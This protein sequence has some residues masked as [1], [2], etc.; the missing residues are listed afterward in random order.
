[1]LGASASPDQEGDIEHKDLVAQI[2][3]REGDLQEVRQQL[4]LA[5]AEAESLERKEAE[6]AQ[7][8]EQV[9]KEREALEDQ[10]KKHLEAVKDTKA[11]LVD[12]KQKLKDQLAKVR[13]A[14]EAASA[15]AKAK[16]E[17]AKEEQEERERAEREKEERIKKSRLEAKATAEAELLKKA[18]EEKAVLVKKLKVADEGGIFIKPTPLKRGRKK[19]SPKVGEG[20]DEENIQDEKV[21]VIARPP[22]L[23]TSSVSTPAISSA[24]SAHNT[25]RRISKV[26]RKPGPKREVVA[27][28]STAATQASSSAKGTIN[29]PSSQ[30]F[31][32]P[33]IASQAK[34]TYTSTHQKKSSIY[35]RFTT[36]SSSA[37]RPKV[38]KNS[39]LP[40][41]NELS[42]ITSSGS[43]ASSP[44]LNPLT[45]PEPAK[46]VVATTVKSPIYEGLLREIQTHKPSTL[47]TAPLASRSPPPS[48]PSP[49]AHRERDIFAFDEATDSGSELG[50][51]WM[52]AFSQ[53]QGTARSPVR[54]TGY[55]QH[56]SVAQSRPALPTIHKPQVVSPA[57][58]AP[59]TAFAISTA[60]HSTKR[61]PTKS[62]NTTASALATPAT[63]RNQP[64]AA[65]VITSQVQAKRF[66]PPPPAPVFTAT[67]APA[68]T[69][70]N[71]SPEIA[72][73]MLSIRRK[74]L[75]KT[76]QAE[77]ASTSKSIPTQPSSTAKD[78]FD[79]FTS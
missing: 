37:S 39:S 41:V 3:A 10:R 57:I 14:E 7:R 47:R 33:T 64:L 48:P 69:V 12:L 59:T 74:L 20:S 18:E 6:F 28:H 62:T 4:V 42:P 5:K 50:M 31:A 38:L 17:K 46:T 65:P 52:R 68:R 35:S 23:S 45:S 77:V 66:A 49:P 58:T 55:A 29:I 61:G 40:E 78:V 60:S 56:H 54:A 67:P 1:M 22:S 75:I 8:Q 30:G 27:T 25:V 21:G 11:S 32:A 51:A 72:N 76:P 13:Q 53:S 44:Y 2:N 26:G 19:K 34:V 16:L 79:F 9:T 73:G 63:S 70:S 43:E 71:H 15:Q 24:K 36:P